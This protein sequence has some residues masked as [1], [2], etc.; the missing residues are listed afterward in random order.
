MPE[1]SVGPFSPRNENTYPD[2]VME[3]SSGIRKTP[4][5]TRKSHTLLVLLTSILTSSRASLRRSLPPRR[6]NSRTRVSLMTRYALG[7]MRNCEQRVCSGGVRRW[8]EGAFARLRG[9]T[10]GVGG[11]SV[12]EEGRIERTDGPGLRPAGP[13]L[14]GASG[15][16]L[17]PPSESPL[18]S[19]SGGNDPREPC[20]WRWAKRSEDWSRCTLV[21]AFLAFWRRT[22][23]QN[24]VRRKVKPV[25]TRWYKSLS[26]FSTSAEEVSPSR[27]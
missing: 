7:R 13:G 5:C 9:A 1:P 26:Y 27:R 14:D 17:R 2:P 4:A 20:R 19:S 25:R 12:C 15:S 11:R 22:L 16:R 24:D 10:N 6:A 21:F 3:G 18:P 8:R 23:C